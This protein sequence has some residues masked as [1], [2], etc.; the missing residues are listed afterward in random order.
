MAEEPGERRRSTLITLIQRAISRPYLF[1]AAV[2][3]VLG[4]IWF[5]RLAVQEFLLIDRLVHVYTNDAQVQMDSFAIRP[6][7]T[8]EVREVLVKEGQAVQK[9]QVLLRL[10][11][12]D[13]LVELR[14]AE[15]VAEG[16]TQQIEEMRQEMPLT[17]VRAQNEVARDQALVETKHYAYRR[18]EELLVVERDRI[19]K[20]LREH[21]ASIEVARA[22]LRVHETATREANMTLQ[23]IHNLSEDG[24]VSQERLD[25][26][27]IAEER[28]QARLVEAQ[29]QLRQV[30]DHYPSRDSPHMIRVHEKELQRL[31]SEVKEQQAV[32]ELARTNLRLANLGEQRLKVLE[33]KHK[34]ALAQVEVYQLKLA[35][36]TIR[37]PVDGVVAY[38]NIESG[39][40]V[41]GDVSNA[42]IL[43]LHNPRSRWIAANIWESDIS[44][45]RVGDTAEIWIDAFKTSVLGRGKPFRGKVVKINPTTYSEV[46]GLPPER[47]FSRRERKVPVGIA[48]EGDDPGLRAG[49]LAEVLLLPRGGAVAEEQ[50]RK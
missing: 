41:E 38:R 4:T 7:V 47:F 22:R 23:R 24:I 20:M 6:A 21:Q 2:L 46:A 13:I 11:Q 31:A 36:T 15:A 3:L 19:E 32:L 12:E 28:S 1:M 33:A 40:M 26:V 43:V 44:R 50:G 25:A 42:P 29:E 14:K 34:E 8:A 27:Q 35:K 45:V 17:I 39:E 18:A 9:G 10:A 30:Q 49:M 16:I 48:I 5:L 37:S